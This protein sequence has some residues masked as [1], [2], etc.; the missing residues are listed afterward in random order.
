MLKKSDGQLIVIK[1]EEN[2]HS[3]VRGINHLL[4]MNTARKV[5]F[6]RNLLIRKKYN[7]L[8]LGK[9]ENNAK[10]SLK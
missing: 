2:F 8:G 4:D 3:K 10:F 1:S 7:K 6:L 5:A 9:R